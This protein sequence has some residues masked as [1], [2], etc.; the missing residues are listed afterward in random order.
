MSY[1]EP[2]SNF[3]V[4][5]PGETLLLVT[6]L[7]AGLDDVIFLTE[8]GRKFHMYHNQG[9]C[10]SVRI[11]D[12]KGDLDH[13]LN[14]PILEATEVISSEN[15]TDIPAPEYQD[16]FTWST[17]T[18]RTAKGV[19]VIRWYGESNGYYGEDVSFSEVKW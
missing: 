15:P 9:C 6:G 12:L 2:D 13:L 17:F 19:V 11:F 5:L 10:E 18:I 4:V 1:Y 7:S 16:S 3:A 14:S 8:S